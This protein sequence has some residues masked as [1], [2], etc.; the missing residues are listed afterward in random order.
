MSVL[1]RWAPLMHFDPLWSRR[2]VTLLLWLKPLPCPPSRFVVW[3]AEKLNHLHLPKK[4]VDDTGLII[5]FQATLASSRQAHGA[6]LQR[7]CLTC[8]SLMWQLYCK[9]W[10]TLKINNSE[11]FQITKTDTTQNYCFLLYNFKNLTCGTLQNQ[12]TAELTT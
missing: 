4:K 9:P 2:S 8:S 6:A 1:V 12:F 11:L 10:H 7:F 3:R 5:R